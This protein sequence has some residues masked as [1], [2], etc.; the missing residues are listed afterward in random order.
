MASR[1]FGLTWWGR[2]W[3][4]ALEALGAVYAN[5]LPRGRTYARNGSVSRLVVEP[6]KVTAAVQGSRARPYRVTITLPVFDDATWE[7]VIAALSAQ[8]RHAAALLDGQMPEDVDEVLGACGV[9]LFPRSRELTTSCSC[10][11]WA[12]PCK[13]VAAVH[14]VLAQTFDADP[15]LLPRLRGR[16]QA[17]LLAGL[18]AARAGV[19][20]AAVDE[21]AGQDCV[22]ISALCARE[23]FT[24][25]GALAGIA[26]RPQPAADPCAPLR[27]L[28]PP[29]GA[30]AAVEELSGLVAGAAEVA[31]GLL[32]ASE[33]GDTD[34]LVAALRA[35]EPATSR[36]LADAMAI[37]D[38]AEIRPRLT[39]LLAT[40][41]VV[42]TGRAR[43]T[44]YHTNPAGGAPPPP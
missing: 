30:A 4:A 15:F 16:D 20:E 34:P 28:G 7:Q 5:R 23:L 1:A 31:W 26:L 18:R 39:A 37:D 19:A 25:R 38:V 9:S 29:P 40:G 13:H 32:T 14:Y 42:R 10:P 22:P 27:R 35:C 11:D 17:A 33:D 41:Q 21:E 3:I 44:R 6:G 2:R 43:T 36:Q 8:L 12:N 24:A